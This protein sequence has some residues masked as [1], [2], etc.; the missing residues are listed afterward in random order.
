VGIG[1]V[2]EGLW[3]ENTEVVD[4]DVDVGMTP[5]QFFRHL[6]FREVAGKAVGLIDF[7]YGLVDRSLRSPVH[8]DL[9]AFGGKRLGD[10]EADARR[11]AADQGAFA[12]ELQ[13]HDLLLSY[14]LAI[15]MPPSTS[16]AVPVTNDESSDAKYRTARAISS[17]LPTRFS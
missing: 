14:G 1:N 9:G 13:I 5:H 2:L 3:L 8:D 12:V 17:G 10:R 16:E 7:R 11:T 15:E 6:G 4:E